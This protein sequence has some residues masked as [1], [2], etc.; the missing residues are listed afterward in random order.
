[1]PAQPTYTKTVRLAADLY[2]RMIRLGELNFS[3]YIT[4]LV[5]E[6][7]TS[8]EMAIDLEKDGK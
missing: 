1:M 4:R 5:A 2:Q 6:D 3:A 7:V 8:R